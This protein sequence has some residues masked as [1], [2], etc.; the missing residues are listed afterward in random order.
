MSSAV[1]TSRCT[2]LRP[3]RYVAASRAAP[4]ST[5]LGMTTP[6]SSLHLKALAQI[7]LATDGVVDKKI[8]RA[9]TLDAPVVNQVRAVYDGESL[10]HVVVSDHDGQPRFAEI[11]NDLL[12]IVN[13]NGVDAAER[14]VEHQQPGLRDQRTGNG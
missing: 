3:T 10:P 9:F 14:L 2:S 5:S 6:A 8:L 12:H 11:N 13:S 1:E 7:K 4:F